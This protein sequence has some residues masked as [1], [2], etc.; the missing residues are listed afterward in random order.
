MTAEGTVGAPTCLVMSG[1]TFLLLTLQLYIYR[2]SKYIHLIQV[3]RESIIGFLVAV[4]VV[5][6]VNLKQTKLYHL[7]SSAGTVVPQPLPVQ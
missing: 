4:K 7:L 6:N 5:Q 1:Q 2:C 3:S